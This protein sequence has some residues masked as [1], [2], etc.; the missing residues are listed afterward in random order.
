MQEMSEPSGGR[1]EAAAGGR[2]GTVDAVD[3]D[4]V[5]TMGGPGRPCTAMGRTPGGTIVPCTGI[6]TNGRDIGCSQLE[7]C[8][9]FSPLVLS[10]PLRGG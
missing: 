4:G 10:S 1:V 3:I 6:V 5:L 2:A 9:E 7:G 8:G